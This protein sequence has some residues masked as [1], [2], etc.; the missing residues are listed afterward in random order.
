MEYKK[1]LINVKEDLENKKVQLIIKRAFDVI[2]SSIGL[3]V[4]SPI[5][6]I[7][8]ILIKIDSKGPVFFKQERV[9]LNRQPFKIFKFR[10]MVNDAEKKGRQIT[11]GSDSRITKVGH[12]IRKYK[13]D[14]FPQLINV[15]KGEMS[16]VGPRPEVPRYVELYDAK[17]EQ[18]LLVK[19]GITDY[20][21][22]EFRNEN[23]I[24]GKSLN[25]DKEYIENIMPSKIDLNMKYIK[26]ISLLTDIKIIMKTLICIIR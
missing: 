7:M 18:I 6:L 19:P 15:F 1:E 16:L 3:I 10:T 24:L 8:S 26:E 22:I 12:F 25:P 9:G 17:Q 14:E 2:A 21:S 11:V 4:L 5:F 13:L 20:A 23:D